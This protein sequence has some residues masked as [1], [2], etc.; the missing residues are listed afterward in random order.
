MLPNSNVLIDA[1]NPR[2]VASQMRDNGREHEVPREGEA[3]FEPFFRLRVRDVYC[4]P[5]KSGHVPVGDV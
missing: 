1:V 2:R 4:T 5:S 3:P